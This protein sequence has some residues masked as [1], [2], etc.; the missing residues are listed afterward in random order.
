MRYITNPDEIKRIINKIIETNGGIFRL[1]PTWIARGGSS[2]PGRRIKLKNIDVSQKL[3]VNERWFASVTY[4]NNG[5]E[6]N[7]ICPPDHGYSYIITDEGLIKL[8]DAIEFC[9]EEM[10]GD[11]NKKWDVLPKVFDNKG[12]LPFHIHPCDKHVKP[13]LKGKPESY[14]FPEELNMNPNNF[15]HTAV[16]VDT[17]VT[18]EE[19]YERILRYK[20]GDNKLTDVG[21]T[22]NPEVGSGWYMPPCTLHAP[23]SLVTY[24]LQVASD[25]NCLPESR[26][27]DW[28]MPSDLLDDAIP[29]TIAKDGYEAVCKY[30]L[31]MVQCEHSGN[32]VHFRKEYNRPPVVVKETEEG[33][34]SYIVYHLAKASEENAPDLFSAKK[35]VINPHKTMQL[36]ENA[37]FGA[38]ILR[39]YGKV[40]CDN[41]EPVKFESVSMYDTIDDYY[42]DE[43][44]VAACAAKTF[45]VEC[46]SYEPMSFYQHFA[47][48]SNPEAT[49]ML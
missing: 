23:G 9:R 26:V 29:V 38:V 34:Q 17:A 22:I 10:L 6:F 24:E 19:V 47:S 45:R 14:F 43:I 16:G 37:A 41:K 5:E 33:K 3:S 31:S 48:D 2:T 49:K 15:P 40:Y 21:T 4:A 32:R 13:G 39:G 11:K 42:S 30:I 44:F 25:V 35:T 8:A 20:D 28:A 7:K 27:D 46:E 18:D 12:R 1:K 36:G